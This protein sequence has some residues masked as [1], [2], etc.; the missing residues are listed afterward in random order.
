MA[1]SWMN[2]SRAT[3]SG[4]YYPIALGRLRKS[5]GYTT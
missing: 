3:G 1:Q 2:Y 4:L 5:F